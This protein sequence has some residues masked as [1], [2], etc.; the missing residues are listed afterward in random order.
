MSQS[1][2]GIADISDVTCELIILKYFDFVFN[3]YYDIDFLR[4]VFECFKYM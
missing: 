3:F 2:V 4:K 1:A